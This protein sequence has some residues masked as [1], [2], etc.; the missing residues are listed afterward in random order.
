MFLETAEQP[1]LPQNNTK[2]KYLQLISALSSL[3][4]ESELTDTHRFSANIAPPPLSLTR[5]SVSGS[6]SKVLAKG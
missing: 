2:Y 3:L 1:F 5:S 4:S 6:D